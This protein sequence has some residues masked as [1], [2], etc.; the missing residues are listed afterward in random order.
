MN[1]CKIRNVKDLNRGTERSAGI[2]F[3]VPKFTDKYL[4]DVTI[5]NQDSL[6]K[7]LLYID[8]KEKLIILA[9][10]STIILP[11]GIIVDLLTTEDALIDEHNSVAFIAFNKSGIATKFQLDAAASVLDEDYRDELHLSVTNTSNRLIRIKED[12]K[13]IQFILIPVMMSTP[14]L[15]RKEDMFL[16]C[17]GSERGSNGFGH[18]GI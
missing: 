15:V 8:K 1:Y 13:L 18:T 3:F 17:K 10:S 9:P 7:D 12:M 16:N 4:L 5:K 11:A 2:D 14:K 6:A